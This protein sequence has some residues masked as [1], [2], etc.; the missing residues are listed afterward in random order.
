MKGKKLLAGLLSVILAFNSNAAVLAVGEDGGPVS[1]PPAAHTVTIEASSETPAAGD[2]VTLTASGVEDADSLQWQEMET[3]WT[4]IEGA[5][6]ETYTFTWTEELETASFRLA[7]SWEGE[8][9][10]V[11]T[12]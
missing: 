2:E 12:V 5:T 6:S 9:E 1:N 10:S 11:E 3:D 4:D 7:A 8:D